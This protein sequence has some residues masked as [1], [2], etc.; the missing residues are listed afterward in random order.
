MGISETRREE[1]SYPGEV[2]LKKLKG[3]GSISKLNV[4]AV[5]LSRRKTCADCCFFRRTSSEKNKEK[6]GNREAFVGSSK[7]ALLSYFPCIVVAAIGSRRLM[8]LNLS[9]VKLLCGGSVIIPSRP[10]LWSGT[11][12]ET[13]RAQ[14]SSC[15]INRC[16]YLLNGNNVHGGR[17]KI[18][19]A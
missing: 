16:S 8:P 10:L 19:L 15:D 11:H 13:V 12:G 7:I 17:C 18:E 4:E 9:T 2:S 3:C 5:A 1:S 6:T 14:L